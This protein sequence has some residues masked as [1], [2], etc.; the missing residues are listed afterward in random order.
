MKSAPAANG[1]RK[2]TREASGGSPVGGI[3]ARLELFAERR[4]RIVVA[5]TGSFGTRHGGLKTGGEARE[6]VVLKKTASNAPIIRGN[7]VP[8]RY[9]AN[10]SSANPLGIITLRGRRKCGATGQEGVYLSIYRHR[11]DMPTRAHRSSL[12]HRVMRAGQQ[13]PCTACGVALRRVL[14]QA[15]IASKSQ[16][17]DESFWHLR[18][19][20]WGRC[21]TATLGPASRQVGT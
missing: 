12:H 8:S 14:G 15:R 11:D 2:S 21:R 18:W 4:E 7:T 10:I 20:S 5:I 17:S 3:E 9:E 19:D 1:T 13:H 6:R 16:T